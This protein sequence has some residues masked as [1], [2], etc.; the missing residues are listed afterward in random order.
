MKRTHIVLWCIVAI[1]TIMLTGIRTTLA[2]SPTCTGLDIIFIIDQ[3]GSMG[4]SPD[5]PEPNDP[6]GLR[7]YG[8]DYALSWLG[9]NQ[10]LIH[11]DAT[12]RVAV[13]NFGT[14]PESVNF[15]T[16]DA[17]YYWE[18]ISSGTE[19]QWLLQEAAL[20]PRVSQDALSR[21]YLGNTNFVT[22]F[23]EAQRLFSR[24]N[25]LGGTVGEHKRA[26]IVLTDGLPY[27][28]ANTS[29]QGHMSELIRN[30]ET[31]FSR[32]SYSI[33]VIALNDTEAHYW[34]QWYADL[35]ADVTSDSTGSR[36]RLVE[37]N[38]TDVGVRFREILLEL[39]NDIPG[40]E[41]MTDVQIEAG[42][43]PIPPYLRELEFTFF[44]AIPTETV[45]ITDSLGRA[46]KALG[47]NQ[48]VY[49][50]GETEVIER[51]QVSNPEPGEWTVGVP[52][53]SATKITMQQITAKGRLEQPVGVQYQFVPASIVY[54]LLD[55]SNNPLPQYSD[56]RYQLQVT[57]TV[58]SGG[59]SWPI[60]LRTSGQS[61]YE[62]EFVPTQLGS[63]AVRVKATSQDLN[64]NEV[65]VFEGYLNPFDVR[66][67]AAES[68]MHGNRLTQY[69]SSTL[70]Y[71]LI[72][73]NNQDANV[74]VPIDVQAII[75]DS[76]G[77]TWVVPLAIQPGSN[78]VGQ[79]TPAS[80]DTHQV[81]LVAT[82]RDS[83][84]RQYTALDSVQASLSVAPP[85][86]QVQV[87][88]QSPQQYRA[89]NVTLQLEDANGDPLVLDP[90]Q[91]SR[92]DVILSGEGGDQTIAV[93]QAS[94][95]VY[96][97][98]FSPTHDGAHTLVSALKIVDPGTNQETT[99]AEIQ[100]DVYVL[101][102]TLVDVTNDTTGL[103]SIRSII[104]QPQPLIIELE[105]TTNGKPVDLSQIIE[106]NSDPTSMFKLEIWDEEGI[107]RSDDVV[108]QPT[109]QPGLFRAVGE[110]LGVGEYDVK[111]KTVAPLK[112]EYMYNPKSLQFGIRRVENPILIGL[113]TFCSSAL[114][115]GIIAAL[116]LTKRKIDL[117]KHPCRGY[118]TLADSTRKILWNTDLDESGEKKM[119]RQVFELGKA[120]PL[121]LVE[122]LVVTCKNDEESELG[123]VHIEATLSSGDK[124]GPHKLIPH[125]DPMP[126]ASG[127][128]WLFK[129][130]EERDLDKIPMDLWTSAQSDGS[131]ASTNRHIMT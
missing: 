38:E 117:R 50:S 81:R 128:S 9:R 123:I 35:W 88:P 8:V 90:A 114:L 105:M 3:S 25:E 87:S 17:P 69:V 130:L 14:A 66:Q 26:I 6:N 79:F 75:T 97:A 61:R 67:L 115:I 12:Y 94:P 1:V 21:P 5:H 42:P 33:Y 19:S 91:Q 43:Q 127:A 102:T 37:Q 95:G 47:A 120:V 55:T 45:E 76:Q 85:A 104:L 73:S 48:G 46:I 131:P 60:N 109:D 121:S 71:G 116:V 118:L 49:V 63:H 78:L 36:A 62:A 20:R 96:T 68:R 41:G 59:Q 34:N 100:Q 106:G 31:D 101:A 27:V 56:L 4:G 82:T 83:Q 72:D 29:V 15:G 80:I 86:M 2:Q 129:N 98:V 57:T 64:G 112:A 108:W 84:G 92:L 11:P 126:L 125:S 24:L 13:V 22:A 28:N 119:N 44:K 89:V 65:D 16:Y 58:Q 23:D 39:T 53:G 18:S 32:E 70:H 107:D 54:Q 51:V 77:N 110:T 113:A 52:V 7:F 103:Q 74:S 122:T 30:V 111:V 93:Q 10:W 99:I 40:E 124:I